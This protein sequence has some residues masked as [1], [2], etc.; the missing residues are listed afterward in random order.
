M[1]EFGA[2]IHIRTRQE[3]QPVSSTAGAVDSKNAEH[4]LEYSMVRAPSEFLAAAGDRSGVHRRHVLGALQT[5]AQGVEIRGQN[6][7]SNIELAGIV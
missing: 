4:R 3:L 5:E 2:H 1:R 6:E 7:L